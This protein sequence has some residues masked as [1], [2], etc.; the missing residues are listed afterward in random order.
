MKSMTFLYLF[1]EAVRILYITDFSLYS[2]C[3]LLGKLKENKVL[4][5]FLD[6]ILTGEGIYLIKA[7]A[8][9]IKNIIADFDH[10]T[11]GRKKPMICWNLNSINFWYNKR[12]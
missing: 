8:Q 9:E 4:K 3:I 5:G 6:D 10:T 2:I 1:C 12:L 11:K 7:E